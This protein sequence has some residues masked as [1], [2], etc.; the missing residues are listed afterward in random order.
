MATMALAATTVVRTAVV[1][2]RQHP[3][4]YLRDEPSFVSFLLLKGTGFCCGSDVLF[5][6]V[7]EFH[8]NKLTAADGCRR[9]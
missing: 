4:D 7:S 1:S 2:Q 8:D 6:T 9:R 3:N 5:A